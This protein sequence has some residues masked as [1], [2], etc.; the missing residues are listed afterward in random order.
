[1]RHPFFVY[2]TL[3][4]GEPN[5]AR[6]LA[7]RTRGEEAASVIGTA[8]Y[9]AGPYPYL[10]AEPDLAAPDEQVSGTLI[11]VADDDY[12]AVLAQLDSLEGYTQGGTNNT[13]ERLLVTVDTTAGPRL[14]WIYV[15]GTASLA[16]IRA[17][18]LP[19]LPGGNWQSD[20]AAR[21]YWS[22]P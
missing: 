18:D 11:S 2:G 22:E 20:S 15:A 9:S 4:P 1:M 7:G 17:G 3:K 6:F 8:L 21:D 19:K 10:V 13:Y 5:Y 12:A 14:A 16:R